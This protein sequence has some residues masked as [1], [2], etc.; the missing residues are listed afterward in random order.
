MPLQLDDFP[1]RPAVAFGSLWMATEWDDR[2]NRIDL[3]TGEIVARIAIPGGLRG[4]GGAIPD[5]PA[6]SEGGVW[7][8]SDATGLD[9][10]LLRIDPATNTVAQTPPAPKGADVIAYGFGSLWVSHVPLQGEPGISRVDPATG[11]VLADIGITGGAFMIRVAFGS[12]WT[13]GVEPE[14][15]VGDAPVTS[16]GGYERL[17]RIDPTTNTVVAKIPY[18]VL[19]SEWHSDIAEAGGSLWISAKTALLVQIDPAQNRIVARYPP[20]TG[21]GGVAAD[22]ASVWFTAWDDGRLH[23]L[24]L[25]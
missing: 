16:G 15:G 18:A 21:G 14:A 23:R 11:G 25:R 5:G 12:V 19:A 3:D 6:A 8:L 13:S 24:P 1:T 10:T 9:R 2:L 20:S 17:N 4:V 7:V 22:G